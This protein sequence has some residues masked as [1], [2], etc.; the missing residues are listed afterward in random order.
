VSNAVLPAGVGRTV[1]G[2]VV[3]DPIVNL[4][5]RELSIGRSEDSH[6]DQVGVTESRLAAV[7][8]NWREGVV[9]RNNCRVRRGFHWRSHWLG[10]YLLDRSGIFNGSSLHQSALA[11]WFLIVVLDRHVNGRRCW[12]NLWVD[13]LF[14]KVPAHV[15]DVLLGTR[16]KIREVRLLLQGIRGVTSS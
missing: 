11:V 13:V 8:D 15:E 6:G 5:E 12:E 1:K 16:L 10:F 9:R 3:A 14:T 7:I 4:G 2:E